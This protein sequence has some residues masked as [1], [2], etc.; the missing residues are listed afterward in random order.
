MEQ[1]QAH[2]KYSQHMLPTLTLVGDT[3][4]ITAHGEHVEP[5]E[6]TYSGVG[7]RSLPSTCSE[8]AP[9]WIRGRAVSFVIVSTPRKYTLDLNSYHNP[10]HASRDAERP[11]GA[12]RS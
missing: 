12:A 10:H 2:S 1:D 5:Y 3:S 11:R 6:R 9:Y 4:P 7:L 8:L